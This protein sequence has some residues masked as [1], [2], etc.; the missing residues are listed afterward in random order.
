MIKDAIVARLSDTAELA[1]LAGRTRK[2]PRMAIEY[3]DG[4]ACVEIVAEGPGRAEARRLIRAARV[5]LHGHACCAGGKIATPRHIATDYFAQ[6]GH[7]RAQAFFAVRIEA[8]PADA[9][10][11]GEDEP[12]SEDEGDAD[13][14]PAG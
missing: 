12:E 8:A 2:M 5:A 9:E 3:R 1:P 10:F 6:P 13:E 14:N 4:R 7:V 11:E